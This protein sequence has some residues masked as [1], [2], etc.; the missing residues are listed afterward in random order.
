V[1]ERIV[2]VVDDE[3]VIEDMINTLLA[4]HGFRT[5]SFGDPQKALHFFQEHQDIVG[6]VITDFNMPQIQGGELAKRMADVNPEIPVIVITGY[7]DSLREADCTPNVKMV[8]EKPVLK[9]ILIQAIESLV[10]R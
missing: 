1:R 6:L 4:R 3:A 8:L 10:D 9:R 5:A 7:M 2:L